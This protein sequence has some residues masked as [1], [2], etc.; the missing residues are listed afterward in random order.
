MQ[1][2]VVGLSSDMGK[3][4][5]AMECALATAKATEKRAKYLLAVAKASPE[6]LTKA[7]DIYARAGARVKKLERALSLAVGKL[8]V[9]TS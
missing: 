3:A 6:L 1:V 2:V 5:K 8:E 7:Q 4:L 9:G